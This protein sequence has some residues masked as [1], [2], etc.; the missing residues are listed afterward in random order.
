MASFK[1]VSLIMM[2]A[3]ACA[4]LAACDGANDI[5]SP[6]TGGN[7]IINNPPA[8]TPSPT[9]TPTTALVTPATGCPTIADPKGLTDAG[10]ITGPTG[11]WRVCTLPSMIAKSITLPKIAGLVYQMSGR[12]DVGCDGGIVAPTTAAPRASTTA[13]CT[14]A[15]GITL[16][17]GNLTAD[18]NVTLTIE[19]GVI[20][21][22]G[23]GTSWLA[24][25]RGNKLNAVGTATAPIIFTSRDN[26]LGLNN[27]QTIGQWGGVV[28][29]GRAKITDCTTGSTGAGTCERQTEGSADPAVF[30]G[31]DDTYNAGSVKYVQIRYSGYVLGADKELQSLT[32]EGTGSGTT[33]DFF[34][35]HNSS[36]DGAEFFGGTVNFKH[37]I[38]SGADDDSLDI[39]TGLQ[40]AF[41]YLLLLQRPGQGD[42]LME[43]DSDGFE[44]DAPR[45]KTDIVNFTAIQPSVSSNNEGSGD[46]GS[47]LVRGNS[48]IRWGNG[49]IVSP[50]NECLRMNG[51]GATPA[52]L[53]A[54]AVVMQCNATKYLATGS[55]SV[56]NVSASFGAGANANSDT[57]VPSLTSLFIN[58]ATEAAVAGFD[59]K[60]WNPFFDTT[61]YIGA[62]KDANDNWYKGWTCNS[63]YAAFDTTT[64]AGRNCLSLPTN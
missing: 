59:V 44:T 15:N 17:G 5:A 48:D 49:I 24:V 11:Q 7:V 3:T 1:R 18:T 10:T 29:M 57:F 39:D 31:T 30:G 36:D 38:A 62:V 28:L 60:T 37:Y 23:T 16:P 41:Q 35:S 58:G 61:T 64:A 54:R 45:Q 20:V 27:D 13:T 46:K 55:F 14:T 33:L 50:N 19:P 2:T 9:P 43:I 26:I 21:F 53:L 25:N 34:Q 40:G 63:G 12:V 52:T 32:T 8:P 4:A 47:T 22:G 6:G 42:A 51:S 56:A